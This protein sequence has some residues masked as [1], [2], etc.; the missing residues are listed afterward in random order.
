[1]KAVEVFNTID[2]KKPIPFSVI[3]D[4]VEPDD[5]ISAG[6]DEGFYTENDSMDAHYQMKVTRMVLET[7]EQLEK[8]KARA[9]QDAKWAKER[10]R[11]SYLRLK[12]EFEDDTTSSN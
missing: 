1:M 5:I 2:Y 6:W 11:E 10:R 4:I 8:R 7:D 3:K 9:E 12:A